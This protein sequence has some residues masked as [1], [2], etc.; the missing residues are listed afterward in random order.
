MLRFTNSKFTEFILLKVYL[1]YFKMY[2]AFALLSPFTCISSFS[3]LSL[4]VFIEHPLLYIYDSS[5]RMQKSNKRSHKYFLFYPLFYLSFALFLHGGFYCNAIFMHFCLPI[6]QSST[7]SQYPSQLISTSFSTSL[8]VLE[9]ERECSIL[10]VCRYKQWK[11]KSI[12]HN[13]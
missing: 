11:Q 4:S 12:L 2:L 7:V 9:R 6:F 1:F 3:P 8:R 10:S 13:D 5:F